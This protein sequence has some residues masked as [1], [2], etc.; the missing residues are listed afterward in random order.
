[1]ETYYSGKA[2]IKVGVN[3]IIIEADSKLDIEESYPS[4]LPIRNFI[5]A[6]VNQEKSYCYKLSRYNY[7]C[8]TKNKVILFWS[9]ANMIH[10]YNIS[11]DEKNP[12]DYPK[13]VDK[14]IFMKE[15]N[16]LLDKLLLI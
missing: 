14:E 11:G 7:V 15:L 6:L 16:T 9:E 13:T 8:F 3:G 12:N 10:I 5:E 4:T 1:M 2:T